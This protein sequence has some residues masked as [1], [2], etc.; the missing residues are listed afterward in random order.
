[1][2]T[3]QVNSGTSQTKRAPAGGF[4]DHQKQQM[5]NPFAEHITDP[6]L[7]RVFSHQ[8]ELRVRL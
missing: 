5:L 3:P 4:R 7:D 8:L 2:L 6:A 1:M